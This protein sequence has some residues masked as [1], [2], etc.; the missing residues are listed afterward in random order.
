[1]LD[2]ILQLIGN[3]LKNMAD[4]IVESFDEII[5]TS[6]CNGL[7]QVQIT[8]KGRLEADFLGKIKISDGAG[9][10]EFTKKIKDNINTGGFSLSASPLYAGEHRNGGLSVVSGVIQGGSYANIYVRDMNAT[11]PNHMPKDGEYYISMHLVSSKGFSS[12]MGGYCVVSLIRYLLQERRW[13]Y[14][15]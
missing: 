6:K 13:C 4:Y 14:A 10:L 11:T 5:S 7:W 8:N 15:R 12:V 3:R 1:M 2:K 9:V